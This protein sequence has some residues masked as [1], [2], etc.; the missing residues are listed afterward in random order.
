M[1]RTE[2]NPIIILSS[3][4]IV[5]ILLVWIISARNRTNAPA[6]SQVISER[7]GF[8]ITSSRLSELEETQNCIICLDPLTPPVIRLRCNHV[9]H[10]NC[11]RLFMQVAIAGSNS[12]TRV[13]RVAAMQFSKS[14]Q[15]NTFLLRQSLDLYTFLLRQSLDLFYS[16]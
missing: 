1:E 11:R 3:I 2:L 8:P 15:F 10:F 12:K 5:V 13:R 9:F 4:F 14:N 7:R 6:R 16:E